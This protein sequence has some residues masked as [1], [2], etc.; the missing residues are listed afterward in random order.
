MSPYRQDY[1]TERPINNLQFF[2][3]ALDYGTFNL[4]TVLWDTEKFLLTTN[5]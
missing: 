2:P 3:F 1:L 5:L 4:T